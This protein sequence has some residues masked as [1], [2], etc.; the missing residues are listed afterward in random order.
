MP[1]DKAMEIPTSFDPSAMMANNQKSLQAI[2]ET[3]QNMMRRM[4]EMNGQVSRFYSK[5]LDSDRQVLRDLQ[6]CRNPQEAVTVWGAFM[7][8]AAQDYAEE[9]GS[10]AA[11]YADQAKGMVDDVTDAVEDAAAEE[12]LQQR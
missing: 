10:I 6:A 12:M 4:A 3:H 1:N 7:E 2:A 8:K 5:R 11:L 9:M